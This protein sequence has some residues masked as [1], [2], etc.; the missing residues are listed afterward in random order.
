MANTQG[1]R[2]W[3]WILLGAGFGLTTA[4]LLD[5]VSG[6]KRRA[7]VRD[8][9]A[10][11]ARHALDY[12]GRRGIAL[13]HRLQGKISELK[14]DLQGEVEVDDITL[15]Q[16]IRSQLGHRVDH[17]RAVQVEAQR[18][19]VVLRGPI[20]YS[21]VETL[22]NCVERVPGVKAVDDRLEVLSNMPSDGTH[23]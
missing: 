18:G 22:V 11:A 2:R 21:E 8:K 15:V 6:R 9:S 12:A 23:H 10:R 5:P 20:V 17:A 3:G 1:P 13:K 4:F 16:R 7:R 19:V 14:R